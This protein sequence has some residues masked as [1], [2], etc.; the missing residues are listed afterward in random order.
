M[1][2]QTER[3]QEATVYIGNLD[4]R[5]TVSLLWEL[6][7]QAGPVVNV[8]LPKDRVSQQT[9]GYGFCEFQTEEDASYAVNIM[10]MVKLY[11]KPLRVNKALADKKPVD[12]GANLF[13][14]NLDP[15][16]DEK[17]LF[18]TF[19]SFGSIVITPRIARDTDTG[20]SK[21]YAFICFDSFEA[22]DAAIEAMDGQYLANKIISV[23]YALK[24][25]GKGERH[26]SAAERLLASQAKKTTD[27]LQNISAN[28]PAPQFQHVNSHQFQSV[29]PQ[30]TGLMRPGMV[31][32][33]MPS[34]N[35]LDMVY[36]PPP[37]QQYPYQQYH[38]DPGYHPPCKNIYF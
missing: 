7:V 27:P 1:S 6:M 21:G 24:K 25:D 32:G 36:I 14:S 29:I 34:Q 22:S 30:A 8:H 10:N 28:I 33:M 18:D 11:G 9:Q 12:V 16:V 23:S 20:N 35:P 15:D 38:Q 3:N 17:M 26:G 4:E 31:P 5:V 2:L 19:S 37:N 13:V